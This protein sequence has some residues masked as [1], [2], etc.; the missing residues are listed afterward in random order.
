MSDDD[1]TVCHGTGQM[2][3][4]DSRLSAGYRYVPCNYCFMSSGKRHPPNF[5]G[6]RFNRTTVGLALL[7][8]VLAGACALFY[9]VYVKVLEQ[10]PW[11]PYVWKAGAVV[12]AI[13]I[14]WIGCRLFGWILDQVLRSP[15]WV[16]SLG[17]GLALYL[18]GAY[19]T[20]LFTA[21]WQSAAGL[22]L[23]WVLWRLLTI[24][25]A[26]RFVVLAAVAGAA[27]WSQM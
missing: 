11:W 20:G 8:M 26:P 5:S 12:L 2:M 14:A 19:G 25:I 3:E 4:N 21:A 15:A 18:H 16:V 13:W 17:L 22:G 7:P 23:L 1:C 27:V 10:Q 24:V 9:A 6:V